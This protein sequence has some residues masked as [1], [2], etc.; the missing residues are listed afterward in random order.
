MFLSQALSADRSC[1]NAVD[2]AAVGVCQG[3]CHLGCFYAA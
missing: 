3:S 1:Q 2:G